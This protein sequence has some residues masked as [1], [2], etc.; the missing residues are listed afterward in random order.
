MLFLLLQIF[1]YVIFRFFNQLLI[2]HLNFCC[3][4]TVYYFWRCMLEHTKRQVKVFFPAF[5]NEKRLYF[6]MFITAVCFLFLLIC[7]CCCC[8]YFFS[9]G[10]QALLGERV[11]GQISRV[12]PAMVTSK[13]DWR[14]SSQSKNRTSY[15]PYTSPIFGKT[16]QSKGY[17][18]LR[19]RNVVFFSP[20]LFFFLIS[21]QKVT[22]P[23]FTRVLTVFFQ[24]WFENGWQ[25]TYHS[26]DFE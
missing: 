20:C 11:K 4:S 1:Y 14:Q 16:S 5:K 12:I 15:K 24:K 21:F 10:G 2:L 13:W 18:H 23:V 22:D 25:L 9:G 17:L 8:C 6:L 19:S 3:Y 26:Q 7:F